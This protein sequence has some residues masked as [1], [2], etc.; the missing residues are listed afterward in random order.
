[1]LNTS[2][3]PDDM[4]CLRLVRISDSRKIGKH[5]IRVAFVFSDTLWE[6]MQTRALVTEFE[7][8]PKEG[9]VIGKLSTPHC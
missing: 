7:K 4:E 3:T 8:I 6:N 9:I 2:S 5:F 1:M